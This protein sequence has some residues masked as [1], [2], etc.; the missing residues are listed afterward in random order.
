MAKKKKKGK[1]WGKAKF[2]RCVASVKKGGAEDPAA[3]CAA[4]C[5]GTVKKKKKRKKK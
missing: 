1:K 2:A 5:R 4:V 3:V